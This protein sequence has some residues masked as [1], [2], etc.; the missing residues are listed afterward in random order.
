M[1]KKTEFIIFII[2]LLCAGFFINKEESLLCAT[3]YSY[4]KVL[5]TNFYNFS[6]TT[7]L[8]LPKDIIGTTVDSY[9]V[10]R[11]SRG[12]RRMVTEYELNFLTRSGATYT[13]FKAYSGFE[14]AERT[15]QK[16]M[17]CLQSENYPCKFGKY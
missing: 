1:S 17:E 7:N 13:V 5:R 14:A 2:M 11:G 6:S 8:L 12:Y 15:G 16:I 10:R 3:Q 4:C 9:Q